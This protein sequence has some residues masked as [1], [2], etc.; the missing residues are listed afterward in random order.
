MEKIKV[1][2][3]FVLVGLVVYN[4]IA[5]NWP[6]VFAMIGLGIILGLYEIADAVRKAE[7]EPEYHKKETNETVQSHN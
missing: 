3:V 2:A 1:L 6:W 7:P 5:G 4:G